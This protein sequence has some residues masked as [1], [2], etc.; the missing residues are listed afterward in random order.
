MN[1]AFGNQGIA[2]Y[3][4]VTDVMNTINNIAQNNPITSIANVATGLPSIFGALASMVSDSA[5]QNTIMN[6]LGMTATP[7]A[8]M[9]E[10]GGI[11]VDLGGG[12]TLD[13]GPTGITTASGPELAPGTAPSSLPSNLAALVEE[14]PEVQGR[15]P[16]IPPV[17]QQAADPIVEKERRK[18]QLQSGGNYFTQAF[19]IDP[20]YLN[21]GMLPSELLAGKAPQ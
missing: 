3:G 2:S 7:G 1:N 18:F 20:K 15:D 11:S 9:T 10:S 19:G 8:S 17:I 12:T 14:T 6:A 5:Q 4:T 21:Y 13:M 16:Y